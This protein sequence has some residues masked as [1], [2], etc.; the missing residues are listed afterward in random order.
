MGASFPA[1][2]VMVEA[3]K[4]MARDENLMQLPSAFLPLLSRFS[5]SCSHNNIPCFGNSKAVGLRI[6]MPGRTGQTNGI[7]GDALPSFIFESG[8]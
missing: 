2:M 5:L 7:A 8:E 1:A 6:G 4:M 3:N